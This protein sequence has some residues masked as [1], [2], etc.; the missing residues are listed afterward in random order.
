MSEKRVF[1]LIESQ[2]YTNEVYIIESKYK[3]PSDATLRHWEKLGWRPLRSVLIEKEAYDRL[4]KQN[5]ILRGQLSKTLDTFAA[6][7]SDLTELQNYRREEI[8]K[9]LKSYAGEV[10]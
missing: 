9:V 4:Q 3:E 6:E 2:K 1:D 8:F 7:E 10:Q 5:E